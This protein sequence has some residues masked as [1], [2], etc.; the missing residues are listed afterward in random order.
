MLSESNVSPVGPNAT[1]VQ[2]ALVS[3]VGFSL[4]SNSA[5]LCLDSDFESLFLVMNI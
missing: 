1:P 3:S 5:E 4:R 2:L